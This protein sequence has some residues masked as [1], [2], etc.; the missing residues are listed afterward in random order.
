MNKTLVFAHPKGGSGKTSTCINTTITF[1]YDNT[2]LIVFDQDNQQHM[3]KF[4]NYR[5][6]KGLKTFNQFKPKNIEE[7]K[8][9]LSNYK[10]LKI[11][12][13]GGFDSEFSRLAAIAA[14]LIVIP[15]NDSE[16][17][18][19]GL[20]DFKRKIMDI[21]KINPKIKCRV[22]V[23]R[24]HPNNKSAKEKYINIFK[25][26]DNFEVFNTVVPQNTEYKKMLFSG[27]SILDKKMSNKNPKKAIIQYTNEIKECLNAK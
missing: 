2:D 15:L 24:V 14:D 20:A 6:K 19:D 21:I 17:E 13:T 27:E 10:G 3:T 5:N 4:N 26:I 12:D 23:N 8:K 1:L 11:I 18:L 25:N 9:F 22:L 16:F 7:L